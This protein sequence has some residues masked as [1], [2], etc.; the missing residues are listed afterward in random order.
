MQYSGYFDLGTVNIHSF[1]VNYT[2]VSVTWD[3][4][5]QDTSFSGAG[6]GIRDF[7]FIN[8]KLLSDTIL[9]VCGTNRYYCMRHIT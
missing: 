1:H 5:N 8:R 2:L 6:T 9:P 4:Q 3:Y 7:A